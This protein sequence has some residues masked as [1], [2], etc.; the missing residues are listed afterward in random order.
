M[1][2]TCGDCVTATAEVGVAVSDA[3]AACFLALRAVMLVPF[4]GVSAAPYNPTTV[5]AHREYATR[6]PGW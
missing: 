6:T 4:F 1:T 3:S 5:P 2:G